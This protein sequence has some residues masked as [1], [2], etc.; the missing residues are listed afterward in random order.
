[1]TEE[2]EEEGRCRCLPSS[3]AVQDSFHSY[4]VGKPQWRPALAEP[5]GEIWVLVA[6]LGAGSR[7]MLL[8]P[9]FACGGI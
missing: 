2:E 7:G 5:T 9:G 4:E 1:M 6:P 3:R 8:K